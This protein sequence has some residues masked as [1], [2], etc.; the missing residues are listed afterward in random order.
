MGK[1]DITKELP[2]A[3]GFSVSSPAIRPAMPT[4]TGAERKGGLS[5]VSLNYY[6]NVIRPTLKRSDRLRF[7]SYVWQP[8]TFSPRLLEKYLV[9]TYF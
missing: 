2:V 9:W 1:G 4:K 8:A 7:D 3:S 6:V 5:N